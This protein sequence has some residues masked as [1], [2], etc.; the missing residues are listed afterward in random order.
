MANEETDL[1]ARLFAQMVP[2]IAAGVIEIKAIARKAGYRSK[3]ALHSG[4]PRVDC[5]GA[6]VGIRGSRIK[7][8]VDL[9]GPERVDVLRWDDSP[10]RL[11]AHALQ[12]VVIEEIVLHPAE[13]RAVVVVRADQVGLANG[14]QGANRELASGLCGWQIE[15][16]ER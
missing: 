6:C 5:V 1:I 7:K 12:P 15:V 2:E 13:H 10:E 9:L 3:L 8:I 4:D 11:I 16:Q 14:R